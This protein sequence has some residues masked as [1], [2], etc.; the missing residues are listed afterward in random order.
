[1]L[2]STT[3][4]RGRTADRVRFV[5]SAEAVG[6]PPFILTVRATA[7]VGCYRRPSSAEMAGGLVGVDGRGRWRDPHRR[8]VVDRTHRLDELVEP[9]RYVESGNVVLTVTPDGG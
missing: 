8:P 9:Y 4:G 3:N 6:E 7:G 1:M 5:G 2:L